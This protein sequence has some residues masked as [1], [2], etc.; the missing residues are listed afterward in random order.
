MEIQEQL[1]E[2]ILEILKR[3]NKALSAFELEEKL[4]L[5][6]SEFKKLII[7]LNKME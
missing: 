4:T 5:D 1:E 3:E 7:T 6:K 2:K